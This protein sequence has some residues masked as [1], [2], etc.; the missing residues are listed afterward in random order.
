[1]QSQLLLSDE[2]KSLFITE[3]VKNKTQNQLKLLKYYAKY[4]RK[5]NNSIYDLLESC[6]NDM[7]VK[8]EEFP[9]ET[10]YE[11]LHKKLFLWEAQ[12]ALIYWRGVRA[13]LSE[14]GYPFTER[15]YQ[16]ATGIVNQML[17]YGYALLESKVMRTIHTW[18][19]S[20]NISYLHSIDGKSPTLCFDLME[21]YR[22]FVV[23]RSV[24]AIITKGEKIAQEES[25]GLLT[26]ETRKKLISKIN[27]RWFAVEKY[28]GK[29]TLLS[30]LMHKLMEN[31]LA[32]CLGEERKPKF[33]T[34]KW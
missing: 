8:Y 29:E 11:G 17:N 23:D 33:Y 32:F 10:G 12:F 26:L 18:Q 5:K 24:I 1:M 3:L 25:S 31:F 34:P 13:M 2:K 27:E 9:Q 20:P 28:K 15:E 7:N 19:L 4:H 21:Q 14:T 16:N 30:E 6:I 22:T